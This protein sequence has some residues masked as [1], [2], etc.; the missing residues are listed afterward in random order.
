VWKFQEKVFGAKLLRENDIDRF[1]EVT[2]KEIDM[3]LQKYRRL[4]I[5]ADE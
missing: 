1:Y 4:L 3:R 2:S 5:S